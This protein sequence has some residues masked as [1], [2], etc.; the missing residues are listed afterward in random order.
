MKCEGA[1]AMSGS[2]EIVYAADTYTGVMKMDRGGQM[3]TMKYT[4]K[5]LGD[6]T[7]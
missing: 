1:Q 3:M 7:Q 5:R 2:G 4:G 6:C